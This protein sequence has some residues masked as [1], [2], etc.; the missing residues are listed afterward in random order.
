MWQ[1]CPICDGTGYIE[2]TS[3]LSYTNIC[4]VCRG[5]CIISSLTGKPP[6]DDEEGSEVKNNPKVP[7]P[8]NIS[9]DGRITY[10][11]NEEEF[12]KEIAKKYINQ[13]DKN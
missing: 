7:I 11:D 3:R 8:P 4:R 2:N 13:I 1:K 9:L 6:K 12:M 5:H 10:T